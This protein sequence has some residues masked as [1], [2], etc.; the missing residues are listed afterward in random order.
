MRRHVVLVGLPGA[1]KSSVGRLAAALLGAAFEDSDDLVERAAGRT[2]AQLFAG[3]GEAAFRRRE[4]EA[5]V[6]ALAR[7]P[8]VIAAGGGWAAQ[9]GNL[10]AAEPRAFTIYLACS[11][12]TAAAR[13]GTSPARPLLAGDAAAAVRELLHRRR[14]FYE[15]AAAMVDTEGRTPAAVAADVAALARSQGGW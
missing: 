8:R 9:P 6:G 1:G 14:P 12:E 15:R 10:E 5:M 11:A 13:A 3:E 4:R 7:P 2:I